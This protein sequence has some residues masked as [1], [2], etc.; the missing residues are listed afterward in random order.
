MDADLFSPADVA[1]L[2]ALRVAAARRPLSAAQWQAAF[3]A[4][5]LMH[6]AATQPRAIQTSGSASGSGSTLA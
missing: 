1:A 4:S 2:L 3:A 6:E 5:G